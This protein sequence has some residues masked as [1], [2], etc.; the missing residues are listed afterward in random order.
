MYLSLISLPAVL[1]AQ[2]AHGAP[3]ESLVAD[4]GLSLVMA[5]L[6]SALFTRLKIPTI[7]AFLVAGVLVGPEFSG[8]VTSK[9]SIETISHLGLVLLLFLIGLEINLKKLLS[10][11]KTLILTGLLQFPL[12]IAFGAAITWALQRAGWSA[13]EGSF[14]PL[15]VGIAAAAS[16]TLLIVK[17]FQE[18]FQL[19]TLVGR[20]VLG[21]LI[22]QDLW[23]MVI[24]AIQPNFARP[25]LM[26]VLYTFLG[27]GLLTAIALV[28]ARYVLPMTFHWIARAPEL[29][30]VMALGW[31][32]GIGMLGTHLGDL[33]GLVGLTMPI[34]VS[35]EMGALI[36]GASIASFP[37]SY[38][39]MTK[40]T[41]VRDFFVTLFFVGL[42]MGIPR[43][44]GAEV[45]LLALVIALIAVLSRYLVFLP[46]LYATGLD[47]R[48]AVI[49]S[50]RL[51]PISEFC[52]VIV[53]MGLGF[54]HLSAETVGAVIFAF[55][56]TALV[57]PVLFDTSDA[58]YHRLAPLLGR[59]G[60]KAPTASQAEHSRDAQFEIALLG[61]HR[62]A[63]SLL[64]DLE[65]HQP[66]RLKRTL[67]VDFNVSLHPEIERR[68]ATAHYGDISNLETLRHAGVDK[69]EVIVCTV[70]DDILKG[71]TNLALV[72]ALRAM[73]PE[74]ILVANAVRTTEV[75]E[76]Y[77]AGADY[78]FLPRLDSARHLVQTLE[79]ALSGAIREYR[80]N[81]V[82]HAGEPAGRREVLP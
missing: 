12:C 13:V 35:L 5:G 62:V 60:F 59:L 68:G 47:Q 20:L 46:L 41:A 3:S 11:G 70:P 40:V 81:Q 6:L 9:A 42:G 66:E 32:F 63:S 67:V 52:L 48:G 36:A 56:L 15:Y 43:P 45:L 76:L 55:V 78:V 82:F 33:L 69:A 80:E 75:A 51:V 44:E 24:L 26:P 10:S 77:A 64:Y 27:I 22:F 31:C 79:A 73:S 16:S 54:G 21:L 8:L 4:I 71:T 57:Y 65:K 37:Y 19:D 49:A 28:F 1:A 7:A 30:L 17:L 25:D 14:L 29:M 39:V 58:I 50:T 61:F 74:A 23:A 38:E 72:K 53:Y 34:S 2:A 18:K